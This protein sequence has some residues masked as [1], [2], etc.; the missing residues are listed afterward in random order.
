MAKIY[1]F[2]GKGGVGKTSCSGAFAVNKAQNGD[3]VLLVSTDPAHSV[4]DLF[5]CKIGSEIVKIRENLFATEINPEEESN[6]YIE[7]IRKGINNIYSPIIVEQ[8]NKQLDAA[9]V[10]PGSH[11][12]AL[13]VSSIAS[14]SAFSTNIN[15]NFPESSKI[16]LAFSKLFR[17]FSKISTILSFVLLIPVPLAISLYLTVFLRLASK[18]FS[19]VSSKS[20]N[21]KSLTVWPVGAVSNII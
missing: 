18:L 16:S 6:K 14:F 17:L 13:F 2:G 1:F 21:V 5:E 15:P 20:G 4:S 8:I 7:G 3:K 9:K 11:E 12:S 19:H 10:S